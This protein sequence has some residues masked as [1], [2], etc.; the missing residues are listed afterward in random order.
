MSIT[1]KDLGKIYADISKKFLSSPLVE[2][3]PSAGDPPEHYRVTYFIAGK[4]RDDNGEITE[5]KEHVVEIAIPFG[6]PLFPPSCTPVTPFFHPDITDETISID[7]FWNKKSTLSDLIKH[8][9]EMINGRFYSRKECLNPDALAWYEMHANQFPLTE[10]QWSGPKKQ[11]QKEEE[12]L[13]LSLEKGEEEKEAPSGQ[14]A[15][16]SFGNTENDQPQD[17]LD[18]LLQ[19]KKKRAFFQLQRELEGAAD[20][21]PSL[22]ELL[23]EAA[24]TIEKTEPLYQKARELE[25]E[26]AFAD[27]LENYQKVARKISDYPAIQTDITRV[28]QTLAFMKEIGMSQSSAKKSSQSTS[29]TKAVEEMTPSVIN[30]YPAVYSPSRFSPWL[31]T[32]LVITILTAVAGGALYFFSKNSIDKAESLLKSCSQSLDKKYY[33]TAHDQCSMAQKTAERA[34]LFFQAEKKQI[35]SSTRAILESAPLTNG[36][37]DK[38]VIDGKEYPLEEAQRT[39]EYRQKKTKADELYLAG[40]YGKAAEDYN[41]A[42][43]LAKEGKLLGKEEKKALDEQLSR[44]LLHLNLQLIDEQKHK[45]NPDAMQKAVEEANAVLDTL[46]KAE[47]EQF[48]TLL[49]LKKVEVQ[50]VS[51]KNKADKA[52]HSEEWEKAISFYEQTLDLAA[53]IPSITDSELQELR[54][55]QARASLYLSLAIGNEA[56]LAGEWDKAIAAYNQANQILTDTSVV[57]REESAQHDR[58]LKKIILQAV[59]IREQESIKGMLDNAEIK[60]AR[61]MYMKV[62][63]II[64]NSPFQKEEKFSKAEQDIRN[65]LEELNH[66]LYIDDKKS[67]LRANYRDLFSR[68]Y[69][70][71]NRS[72]LQNPKATVTD[73]NSKRILFRLQCSDTSGSRTTT[74]LMTCRYD[75]RRQKWTIGGN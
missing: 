10:L 64:E 65:K 53:R 75:K 58:R 30:R 48:T 12:E 34:L 21:S 33:Q 8:I 28:E 39:L 42:I 18:S 4:S 47:Q 29:K 71:L 35:S 50:F 54:K 20:Y 7:D 3:A 49:M 62:L 57:S 15:A 11:P 43:Q 2:V 55:Q 70:N 17:R 13:V 5:S 52:L 60:N 16:P 56:F 26:E 40:K 61:D 9:G 72:K 68:F 44:S 32:L 51:A 23:T 41:T 45:N 66:Q 74:L 37:K 69:S 59:I 14:T 19:L 27:A 46:P 67:Y 24:T 63:G 1:A 31:I 22:Q 36:L 38:M 73:E 25:A 6:F